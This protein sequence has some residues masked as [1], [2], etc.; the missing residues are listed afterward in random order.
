MSQ[1]NKS[2]TVNVVKGY[3]FNGD[4]WQYN[5][6]VVCS[7]TDNGKNWLLSGWND[8]QMAQESGLQVKKHRTNHSI[9]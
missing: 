2:Y 8:A 4:G 5:G 6:E 1:K 3:A 7:T 9:V